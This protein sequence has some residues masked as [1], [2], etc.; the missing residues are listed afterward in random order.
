MAVFSD[1][2]GVAIA[3]RRR[4]TYAPTNNTASHDNEKINS[5]VSFAFLY[6]YGDPLFRAAGAPL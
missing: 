6:G 3:R 2:A 1:A 5:W 4:R